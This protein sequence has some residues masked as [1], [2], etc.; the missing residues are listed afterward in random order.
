VEISRGGVGVR[1][2]VLLVGLILPACT[3]SN[4]RPPP[5]LP[6][7]PPGFVK[8]LSTGPVQVRGRSLVV[9]GQPF[10]IRGVG[11][12]P[13][14]IGHGVD[15]V[16]IYSD[17]AIYGR[18][19]PLLRTLGANAIRTWGLVT[20]HG[21]LRAAYNGGDQPIYVIMGFWVEPSAPL[22]DR[23]T[24]Q[25]I[26]DRFRAYVAE[27]K[28]EPAVLMWSVGNEVNQGY[29]G[30]R[31]DWYRLLNDL[32]QVAYAVEGAAWHPVATAN[33]D[34]FHLGQAADAADDAHLPY[35]DVWGVTAYR[36]RTFTDLFT[37]YPARSRK[38]LWIA[39]F[40]LDAWDAEHGREDAARQAEDDGA[41]WDALAAQSALCVGGTIM[42]Y[43]DEWWKA[44]QPAIHNP[45]GYPNFALPDRYSDEEW[46]GLFAVGPNPAG[47]PDLLHPRPVYATLRARWTK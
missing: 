1:V 46:Y 43:T 47:G 32:G 21:L 35:L 2:F 3:T 14:P 20:S 8:P 40:G 34:L 22:A 30:A 16:A 13:T 39:E 45:G 19:L 27:Y 9:H 12:A 26:L 25:G 5:N 29:Q 10:Q 33:W 6:P 38:P 44:G 41:L 4:L 42:A 11:Y 23:A 36:G 31:A 18:D 17:P 15:E 7:D 28:D 24:R 37:T